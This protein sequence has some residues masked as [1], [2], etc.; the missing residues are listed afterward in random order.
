MEMVRIAGGLS[1]EG[2]RG[3]AAYVYQHQFDLAAQA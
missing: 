2:V 1:H 3:I